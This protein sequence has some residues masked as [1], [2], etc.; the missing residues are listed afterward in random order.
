MVNQRRIL[1]CD[2]LKVKATK[3]KISR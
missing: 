3:C 1:K 2:E